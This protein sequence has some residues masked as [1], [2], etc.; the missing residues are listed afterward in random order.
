MRFHVYL[1]NSRIV[2][3]LLFACLSHGTQAQQTHIDPAA[4]PSLKPDE[5]VTHVVRVFSEVLRYPL[6][7]IFKPAFENKKP[8]SYSLEYVKEGETVHKWTQMFTVTGMSGVSA[9]PNYTPEGHVSMMANG[10]RGA[11]PE[12]FSALSRGTSLIDGR[13]AFT[14]V[15]SCG[16]LKNG[17]ELYSETLMVTAIKGLNDA[18]S[19][20]WAERG[21]PMDDSKALA[22]DLKWADR[23]RAMRPV[24]VCA[25]VPGETMPY[26]SC[27]A[28]TR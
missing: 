24:L 17:S 1:R 7:G 22:N 19:L 20:Q 26:P 13:E 8:R 2:V 6:P 23:I 9:M 5:T 15:L 28:R 4:F 27:M 10:F 18:Y 16:T 21:T 11:C 12:T 3:A 25:V 14:A